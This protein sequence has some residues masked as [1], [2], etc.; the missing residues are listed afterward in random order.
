MGF[1]SEGVDMGEEMS[2][3]RSLRRDLKMEVLN[4]GLYGLVVETNSL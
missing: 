1:I 3:M 2:F 4:K